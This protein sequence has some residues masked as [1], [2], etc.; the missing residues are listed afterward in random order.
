M[1]LIQYLHIISRNEAEKKDVIS[2]LEQNGFNGFSYNDKFLCINVCAS[3]SYFMSCIDGNVWPKSEI[4]THK[5]FMEKYSTKE[6]VVNKQLMLDRIQEAKEKLSLGD[7]EL[8]VKLCHN[9]NYISRILHQDNPSMEQMTKVVNKCNALILDE[10]NS[11]IEVED[12]RASDSYSQSTQIPDAR[13]ISESEYKQLINWNADLFDKNGVKDFQI[14]QLKK[15]IEH[16]N[17][18][19]DKRNDLYQKLELECKDKDE[20]IKQQLENSASKVLTINN[21]EQQ[22]KITQEKF[23]EVVDQKDKEIA[24]ANGQKFWANEGLH[25]KKK[26]IQLL[27]D[28][29]NKQAIIY[30]IVIAVLMFTTIAG[31]V[32]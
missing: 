4:L 2:V 14:S 23:I 20:A 24:I 26:E 11:Q 9:R 22:L 15:E 27:N 7:S 32:K 3:G 16:K 1:K 6:S 21:L 8:S 5:Q 13:M 10:C 12:K 19:L 18:V 17:Q 30:M 25:A 29:L 31:F 28:K